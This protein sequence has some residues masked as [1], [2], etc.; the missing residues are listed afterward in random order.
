[1]I[2]VAM[3]AIT[4]LFP[5]LEPIQR[6]IVGDLSTDRGK[7]E[8]LVPTTVTRLFSAVGVGGADSYASATMSAIAMMGANGQIPEN[9]TAAEYQQ[10]L[11][12]ARNHARMVGGIKA[13]VGFV[14][15]GSPRAGLTGGGEGLDLAAQMG[16]N[17]VNA[18]D[19]FNT[20]FRELIKRL[21]LD[22]GTQAYLERNPDHDMFDFINPSAFINSRTDSE[23][24]AYLP[25]SV[26]IMEHYD[27]NEGWYKE[28]QLGGPWLFPQDEDP[29]NSQAYNE[30]V[31]NGLRKRKTD[32]EFLTE[33]YR[34][35]GSIE[36]YKVKGEH[37]ALLDGAS[38]ADRKVMEEKF[39]EWQ[40]RFMM[41]HPIFAAEHISTDRRTR[42]ASV[43]K[44]IIVAGADPER[45]RNDYSDSIVTFTESFQRY[46]TQRRLLGRDGTGVGRD[47]LNAH[48]QRWL[49]WSEEYVMWNPNTESFWMSIIE[50]QSELN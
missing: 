16:F 11:D 30:Q 48:K 22:E 39:K 33:F 42:R 9:P 21:G 29:F 25:T 2:T 43:L 18:A 44:D 24:G 38:P 37:E 5:E 10:V 47:K 45:P 50:P 36:F 4:D 28:Y 6:N 32:E 19:M 31:K 7:L 14:S 27:D 13:L 12:R 17:N 1:M 46:D 8:Q 3:D 49:R 41:L 34:K 26:T 35:D 23:S 20:E 40:T 15:P